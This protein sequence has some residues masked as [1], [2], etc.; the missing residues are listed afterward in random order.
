MAC[1][2]FTSI[3]ILLVRKIENNLKHVKPTFGMLHQW[4]KIRI[5]NIT[6]KNA[7]KNNTGIEM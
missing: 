1:Q 3:L 4:H 7:Q 5:P 2:T 6:H